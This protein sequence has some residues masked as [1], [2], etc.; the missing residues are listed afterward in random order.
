MGILGKDLFDFQRPLT[1]I[2]IQFGEQSYWVEDHQ[3]PQPY[4]SVLT[5]ILN[6]DLSPIQKQLDELNR[7]IAEQDRASAPRCFLDLLS[8]FATLP[9]YRFH[10]ENFRF[11]TSLPVEALFVGEALERFRIISAIGNLGFCV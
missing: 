5:E 1:H 10:M 2:K 6:Y 9:L 8:S 4:G 3:E 11:F 7:M